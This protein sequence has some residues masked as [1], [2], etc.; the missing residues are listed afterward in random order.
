MCTIGRHG[1]PVA[2]HGD[3]FA[4]PRQRTQVV[5]YDVEA[6]ARRRPVGSRIAQERDAEPVVGKRRDVTFDVDLAVRVRGLGIGRRRLVEE[7]AARTDPV[8]AARGRIDEPLHPG[9][10][11][12]CGYANGTLVVDAEGDLGPVLAERI[13][14]QLR[15]VNDR[16]V[17]REILRHDRAEVPQDRSRRRRHAERIEVQAA[18][19]V[20]TGIESGDVVA[21]SHQDRRHSRA[22]IAFRPGDQNSHGRPLP[23]L[24]RCLLRGSGRRTVLPTRECTLR[25]G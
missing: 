6:H 5:Q 24:R 20:E 9:R 14:R 10:P 11:G 21:V 22:N 4:R 13:V 3:L 17:A 7:V 18:I 25:S 23:R 19:A 8:H 12:G 15:E 1:T 16:I 2:G